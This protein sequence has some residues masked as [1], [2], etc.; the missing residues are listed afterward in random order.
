[1]FSAR[2]FLQKRGIPTRLKLS[3]TSWYTTYM[4]IKYITLNILE[5]GVFFDNIATFLKQE[6]PD[7]VGFQEVYNGESPEFPK[8]YR[9]IQLLQQVLQNYHY[10][11]APV[12]SEK[13]PLGEAELGNAIFSRYPIVEEKNTFFDIP[14]DSQYKKELR[15]GDF[16]YEPRSVQWTKIDIEELYV[17]IF[18]VHGIWGHDGDDNP[19]RIKMSQTILDQVGEKTKVILAGDFNVQPHTQTISMIEK[20]LKNIFKDELTSTFNMRHKDNPGYATAVVDMIFI[21]DDIALIEKTCSEADVS[22]H[23]PLIAVLEL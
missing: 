9:S 22:D 8:K 1:M 13:L 6:Q 4:K 11:F 2:A 10:S 23:K 15:N 21:S 7:I 5:G 16:S 20:R 12:F 18:N 3:S 17:N 19:R 14:Y